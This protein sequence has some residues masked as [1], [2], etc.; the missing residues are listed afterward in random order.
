MKFPAIDYNNIIIM[1]VNVIQRLRARM[2]AGLGECRAKVHTLHAT[3]IK[4]ME[5]THCSVHALFVS[6]VPMFLNI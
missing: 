3:V 1:I 5:H 2:K 6:L 4:C